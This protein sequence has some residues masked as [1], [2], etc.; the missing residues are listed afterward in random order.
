[1]K[2]FKLLLLVIVGML[3]FQAC[4]NEDQTANA[5]DIEGVW[6][7]NE[8]TIDFKIN[9]E[10][11][12]EYFSEDGSTAE[13]IEDILAAS[14]Q[15]RFNGTLEFNSDGSYITENDNGATEE[16]TWSINSD[17]TVLTLNAGTSQEFYFDVLTST[18]NSLVLNRT[19]TESQD[20]DFDGTTEEV[21]TVFDLTLSK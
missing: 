9:G 3:A 2:I 14:V 15:Y 17:G 10:S 1:M 13:L 8:F 21:S 6:N 18:S 19:E 4:N 5:A 7:V 11:F 20:I 16:G 12:S